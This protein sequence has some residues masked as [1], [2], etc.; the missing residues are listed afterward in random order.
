MVDVEWSTL[1]FMAGTA[2]LAGGV[3]F[4]ASRARSHAFEDSTRRELDALRADLR[5]LQDRFEACILHHSKTD[6][7]HR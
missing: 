5:H 3:A 2:I 6:N 4:G 1:L 7:T